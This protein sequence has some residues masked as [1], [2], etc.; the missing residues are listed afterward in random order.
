MSASSH[1]LARL[2]SV[3]SRVDR[4]QVDAAVELVKAAWRGGKQTITFGNG[5]S[6]LTAAHFITDWNKGI[7][8]ASGTPF[9]GRSLLDNIGLLTA[10]AN[11]Q[12]YQDAFA[13]QVKNVAQPGDLV[14]AV[15]GSGNSENVIRAIDC[16]N[17]LGCV[18]LGLCG[19]SGG[20]LKAAARHH[21][22]IDVDDMQIV[23]D[24]HAVFGHIVMQSLCGTLQC[25]PEIAQPSV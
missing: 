6:A 25:L 3:I 11:D 8:L 4:D 16:A 23:E 22:W 14:I 17:G 24:L 19:F 12:G 2:S 7:S 15:S 5:G 21:L 1:Y 18:T 20:R 13:E 10:H 9:R